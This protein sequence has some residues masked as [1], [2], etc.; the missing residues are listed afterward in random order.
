MPA[1]SET[2][3]QSLSQSFGLT[4][5]ETS[6]QSN[7]SK[8]SAKS[9]LFQRKQRAINARRYAEIFALERAQIEAK[10]H[11]GMLPYGTQLICLDCMEMVCDCEGCTECSE[12]GQGP[13]FPSIENR[14][15]KCHPNFS[16]Y[17]TDHLGE[18]TAAKYD[19]DPDSESE[20]Q[21][22]EEEQDVSDSDEETDQ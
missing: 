17:A 15:E 2:F 6:S 19:K 18:E 9:T 13:I 12:E 22:A 20:E 11:G 14:C 5:S 3:S 16:D 10:K 21:E 8:M 4:A 7:S 1:K